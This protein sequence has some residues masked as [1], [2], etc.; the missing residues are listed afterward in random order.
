MRVSGAILV[1]FAAGGL[2]AQYV[3]QTVAGSAFDGDGGAALSA[4]LVQPQGV[5]IDAEGNLYIADAGD[6]RVRK[7][8][9]SG[10]I[11]AF[12]GTG[13][14]GFSGDGGPA[15]AA[16]LDRPYGIALDAA[17]NLYIADLG[18]ARIRMV[19]AGGVMQTLAGGGALNAA[20]G[21]TGVAASQVGLNSPRNVTAGQGGAV[22]FSDFGG[23]R[24]Y[25]VKRGLV[26]VF[27]GTGT[28]GETGDGGVAAQAE[29]N[30]PAGVAAD[31]LGNVYIAD[32]GSGAIREVSG[33]T[34]R[35]V[36]TVPTPVGM[37]VDAFGNPYVAGAGILGSPLSGGASKMT[38][39]DLA[40]D[41]EGNI[42]F[43]SSHVVQKLTPLSDL[44]LVA[45]SGLSLFYGDNGAA[46]AARMNNPW[47]VAVDG[48]GNLFIADAGNNRIRKVTADGTITT[49][50][51][52]GDTSVLSSPLG[53]AVDGNGTL[54]IADS[55]N[56]QVEALSADGAFSILVGQLKNPS[57]VAVDGAGDVFV[58]DRGNGRILEVSADGAVTV[59]AT[60]ADP[61]A[62]AVDAAGNLY[63]SDNSQNALLEIGAQGTATTLWKGKDA[64]RGVVVDAQGNVYVSDSGGNRVRTIAAGGAA[65][66]IAGTGV[67][68]FSGDGAA[69]G[70]AQLHGPA[71]LALDAFG[72]LFVADAGNNRVRKL[73]P[74]QSGVIT[75]PADTAPPLTIANAASN[76]QGAIASG[77]IVSIYGSGFDP[78]TA[79]VSFNG[80][81]ARV[82]YI[83]A[84]QIN[85]LA[86]DG[87]A[88]GT[89]ANLTVTSGGAAVGSLTV[90]V[91]SAT[92][93]IFTVG[94]TGQAAATNQD[95]T[96][97]SDLYPAQVGSI[98]T[99][100]ATGQGESANAA[101]NL[102]IG[103]AAAAMLYAGPAPGFAGLMQI[104]ARVPLG[105]APG[106]E[107]VVLNV[108]GAVSQAGV[109]LA[110]K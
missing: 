91:A 29:L 93:G 80:T 39:N 76:Q 99:L 33:G 86:P 32:S 27:A 15:A 94:A 65:A 71:G 107:P 7:V 60:V 84:G 21:G 110:V 10:E 100:F 85:A 35:T 70:A 92:P 75:P 66:A 56:N 55:G 6:H 18:N 5:A 82:F 47:A 49:A 67:A 68:G 50:A 38:G 72:D 78:S 41:A 54:Y 43:S 48:A 104:N 20:A 11:Q 105:I 31:G 8:L 25:E 1:F 34:I 63:V 97:N 83:G 95:G 108:G 22:Y 23:Q 106:D 102:S 73:T 2:Q 53:V 101:A 87:L 24:V 37:A 9:P 51:G 90:T 74:T 59:A 44:T 64:P 77:E 12:A 13:T 62:V 19:T 98:V 30:Y 79:E 42:V 45:G 16:Q 96:A 61:V 3:I 89:T 40:I 36:A 26:T 88:A 58:A 4:L 109:T 57:A 103:G 17:G 81:A 69:A 46:T 14:A 28:A 52:D